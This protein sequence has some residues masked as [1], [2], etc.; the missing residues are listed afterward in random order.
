VAAT[1]EKPQR[2]PP[3]RPF[4]GKGDPRN[5]HGR[6]PADALTWRTEKLRGKLPT[7]ALLGC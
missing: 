2:K 5:G 1:R 6:G 7:P 4:A 3:G